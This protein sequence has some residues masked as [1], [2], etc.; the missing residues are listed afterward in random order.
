MPQPPW[1][2]PCQESLKPAW[3]HRRHPESTCP[4]RGGDSGQPWRL[5]NL[6]TQ[7]CACE[8]SGGPSIFTAPSSSSALSASSRRPRS[9]RP[10]TRRRTSTSTPEDTHYIAPAQCAPQLLRT[11][12]AAPN[13]C[14]WGQAPFATLRPSGHE[15]M[16]Q[17]QPSAYGPHASVAFSPGWGVQPDPDGVFCL[18]S[19]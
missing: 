9:I 15:C 13:S 18:C 11:G 7:R 17:A 8:T 16:R 10:P 3:C 19:A 14:A 6:T 12:A 4:V 1:A 2:S 5:S